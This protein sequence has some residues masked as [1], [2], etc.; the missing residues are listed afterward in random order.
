[1]GLNMIRNRDGGGKFTVQ[2]EKWVTVID[3]FTIFSVS[4]VSEDTSWMS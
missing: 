4:D 1:M 3:D 2:K